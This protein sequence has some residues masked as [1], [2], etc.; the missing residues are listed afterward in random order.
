MALRLC[1]VALIV[2]CAAVPTRAQNDGRPDCVDYPTSAITLPN[3]Y[4]F[5]LRRAV[6]L[7]RFHRQEEAL[8]E[9][10]AARRIARSPWRWRVPPDQREEIVS[11][12]DAL[13][14][15]LASTR[16]PALAALTVRV[17]GDAPDGG[18]RQTAQAGARVEVE[19]IPVGRTGRE[20]ALTVRVPAGPI[21]VAAGIPITQWNFAPVSLAPGESRSVEIALSDGKEVNEG[22]T[23]VLAEASDDIVPIA[24]T[25]LTLEFTRKGRLA[26]VTRIDSIAA[27]SGRDGADAIALD[28]YFRVV[29]GKIVATNPRQ[30]FD[31]LAPQF[32]ETIQVQ[33]QAM[34]SEHQLHHGE[35]GFR[36][37]QSPLSIR[38]EAPPSNR[39][40]PVSRIAVGISLPG[41]G[42]A[43]ERLSDAQGRLT[44]DS[45]PHGTVSIECVA[46]SGG[47][48]YYG[49]ATLAHSKPQ[50]V[51]VVLLNVND[52]KAGVAPLRT[53]ET[54]S[55]K[56][57]PVARTIQPLPSRQPGVARIR[58]SSAEKDRT[59]A[60]STPLTVGRGAECVML[61]YE[62]STLE[63]R[64]RIG[65]DDV[66]TLALLGED[67]RAMLQVVRNVRSQ[68]QLSPNW[69]P[70]D[71]TGRIQ[72]FFNISKQSSQNDVHL[73]LVATATNVSDDQYPTTVEALITTADKGWCATRL[74][75]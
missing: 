36:V 6:T 7:F 60:M 43:V 21:E 53:D 16:A 33:V 22:T 66:W 59:I 20:G 28:R 38:L 56:E 25:S 50:S 49:Q 46:V 75:R 63:R 23:L 65:F 3:G 12:I 10:D 69:Q 8:R 62:V 24:S 42:I 45:F 31:A 30:V 11:E 9:L 39:A 54:D 41:A 2:S 68:D 71:Q 35:F 14:R 47:K 52:V 73:T 74:H 19:G 48:Y 26:P 70:D 4:P 18:Q 61:A 67:G 17:I 55:S 29:R 13:R 15:C 51:T 37:G 40:L 34:A 58:V 57:S 44:V 72:R 5:D 27:V 32:G 1:L 64:R